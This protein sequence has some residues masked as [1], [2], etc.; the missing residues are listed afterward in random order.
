MGSCS[1]TKESG[2][3]GRAG[4]D[5]WAIP[6]LSEDV[7]ARYRTVVNEERDMSLLISRNLKKVR[8]SRTF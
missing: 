1:D 3:S 8:T 7:L 6:K 2:T 4:N 5:V